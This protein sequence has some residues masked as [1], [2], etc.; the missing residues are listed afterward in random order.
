MLPRKSQ[1]S[2][3]NGSRQHPGPLDETTF[4]QENIH[5]PWRSLLGILPATASP[6]PLEQLSRQPAGRLS[7]PSCPARSG[8]RARLS[9]RSRFLFCLR[10]TCS[11]PRLAAQ[12]H[13]FLVCLTGQSERIQE[14][15]RP[16]A[17]RPG[18]RETPE[19][20]KKRRRVMQARW[21]CRFFVIHR[22]T[23]DTPGRFL[24]QCQV[25]SAVGTMASSAGLPQQQP[26]PPHQSITV[27]KN[28]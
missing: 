14:R 12:N 16:R 4:R 17:D 5:L 7:R 19:E 11:I 25:K 27:S 6:R 3:P 18:F 2:F 13:C 28:E 23:R 8:W 20:S 26:Q 15:I 1:Q 10:P 21:Q 24:G 9:C 22:A